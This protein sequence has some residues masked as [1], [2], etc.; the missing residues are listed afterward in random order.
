VRTPPLTI[1][2][3]RGSRGRSLAASRRDR[4]SARRWLWRGGAILLTVVLLTWG[5][6]WLLTSPVFAVA[7]VQTGRYRFSSQ[8]DVEAVLGTCLGQNIWTLTSSQ[9]EEAFAALPWVRSVSLRRRLPDT[10]VVEL[11][12][13]RPL[14]TVAVPEAEGNEQLLLDDGRILTVPAHLTTPG[15]PL[16]TGASL[17]PDAD[18]ERRLT[19]P[20][21]ALVRD[22]VQALAATGLESTCPVDFVHVTGRGFE[23][24]LQGRAGRL[25]LGYEDFTERIERY[26]LARDRIPAG[27]AVDLRFADRIT[28]EPP[29]SRT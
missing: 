10:L 23:V 13:W 1:G 4:P 12:E 3:Y 11:T 27:A 22:L 28:F 5:G 8:E 29:P 25:L 6:H 16:L 15:L 26:L 19:M 21:P 2:E 9:V 18:G 7:K 14:L 17:E 24:I 20:A